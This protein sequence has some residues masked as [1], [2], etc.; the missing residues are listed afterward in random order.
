MTQFKDKSAKNAANMSM[1]L[2]DYP[3][4][5]AGG[6]IFIYNAEFIPVGED[7]LQHLGAHAHRRP[8]VQRTL[9]TDVPRTERVAHAN[10]ARDV[11]QR[12]GKK[13]VQVRSGRMH[14][15]G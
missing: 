13:N 15:P 10:T 8:K 9:R 4:L 12:S 7:Q 14:L 11:A 1:G 6:C 5:M 2:F 3:V